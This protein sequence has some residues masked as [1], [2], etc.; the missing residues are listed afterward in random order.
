MKFITMVFDY[1]AKNNFGE[2][3]T[4]TVEASDEAAAIDALRKYNLVILSIIPAKKGLNMNLSFFDRVGQKDLAVFSRQLATLMEAKIPLVE[5]LRT[6]IKQT[7]N[8]YLKEVLTD[9]ANNINGGMALSEALNKHPKA[10]SEFYVNMVK[11]GEMSGNLQGTLSYLADYVES[12]YDLLKKVKGAM[13]YPAFLISALFI[14]IILMMV[15]VIPKLAGIFS[16][17][18]QQLPLPTRILMGLSNFSVRFWWLILILASA[19]SIASYYFVKKT[20]EGKETW[21]K[22]IL[23]IPVF[24]K[25]FK[26]VYI[27]RLSE[28]LSTLISSGVPIIGALEIVGNII[29]NSQYKKIV[30]IAIDKVKAGENMS[31]VFEK[32]PALIP[33]LVASIVSVGERTGK[34]DYVLKNL[35]KSYK[36]D[37][38][39]TVANISKLIEP[40][41]MIV[42]GVLI[43]V[44][45]AAIIMPIFGLTNVIK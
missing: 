44:L 6:L 10:F 18:G 42:M 15:L 45:V 27:T 2:I 34:L 1:K 30:L 39:D 5:S 12:N 7:K 24:G 38:D 33:S 22:V 8:R 37:V 4:G 29:G 32:N 20:K 36:R 26:N 43:A 41:L 19:F 17:V 13:I 21:D 23:K 3:R 28:N 9:I 14:V 40:I 35:A 25:V 11:A 16:E 31:L